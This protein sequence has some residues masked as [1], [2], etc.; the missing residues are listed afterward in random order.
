M[1]CEVLGSFSR[2]SLG[3]LKTLRFN[4]KKGAESSKDF[5]I[6]TDMGKFHPQ[7][8]IFGPMKTE[9][10][11]EADSGPRF[12]PKACFVWCFT[13]RGFGLE[14]H[15]Q[16]HGLISS[17]RVNFISFCISRRGEAESGLRS[18][19]WALRLFLGQ[20]SRKNRCGV[21]GAAAPSF[22][23]RCWDSKKLWYF[24]FVFKIGF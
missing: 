8:L 7:E 21:L 12:V 9:F 6:F 4:P 2:M 1:G 20:K 10:D 5:C 3:G 11:W 14:G 17:F 23:V 16:E 15:L 13:I 22:I 18:L 24:W 19:F